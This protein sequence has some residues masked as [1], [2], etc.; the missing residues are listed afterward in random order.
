MK[1][2]LIVFLIL[3]SPIFSQKKD[4][5]LI[6]NEVVINFN[7]INDYKVDVNIKVDI[8]FLKV[9][10]SNA[11]IFFKQP[12]RISLKSEGFAMLPRNGFDFSPN[13]LLK[14]DYT[15]IYEREEMIGDR[16]LA[17]IKV[18]PLGSSS[19]VILSTLWIDEKMNVIR[20]V[21][22]TT[23]TSGTFTIELNYDDKMKYPLPSN[24]V[25]SFNIDKMNFPSAMLGETDTKKKSKK[26]A[27]TLTKGKVYV[28][29]SNYLVNSGIQDSVFEDKNNY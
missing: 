8:E 5:N 19:E 26:P 17:V 23:K 3:S 13:S 16:S 1:K 28:T 7:K 10:E 4:P 12:D 6:L 18:I 22:S 25:F 11:K 29:Y 27:D 2:V 21:E 9:P 24:M 15:A 20:K 14:G